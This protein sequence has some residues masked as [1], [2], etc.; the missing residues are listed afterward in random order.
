MWGTVCCCTLLT[1]PT[2]LTCAEHAGHGYSSSPY[3]RYF[4]PLPAPLLPIL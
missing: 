3:N 4:P 1:D 2:L